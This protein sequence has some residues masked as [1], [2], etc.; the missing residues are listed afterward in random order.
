ML[1]QGKLRALPGAGLTGAAFLHFL[2]R[3]LLNSLYLIFKWTT[4]TETPAPS[5]PHSRE[6]QEQQP[7]AVCPLQRDRGTM[8]APAEG[9]GHNAS[10]RQGTGNR[11]QHW[12][13]GQP[14]NPRAGMG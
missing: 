10:P 12:P 7:R 8:P 6:Q 11:T 13:L 2:Q 14:H 1:L 5:F 4:G 9:Q 3:K